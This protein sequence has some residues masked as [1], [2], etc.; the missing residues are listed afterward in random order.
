MGRER[1]CTLSVNVS[2]HQVD[3]VFCAALESIMDRT[4]FPAE[5]LELEITESAL[6][7]DPKLALE[8]LSRWKELG[9]RIALDDFGTGYCSLSYLSQLPVDRVKLDK[10]FTQTIV[11]DRRNAV[12]VRAVIDLCGEMG[13]SVLAEGVETELQLEMLKD[14]GCGHAQGYLMAS[15]APQ[16]IARAILGKRWGNRPTPTVPRFMSLEEARHAS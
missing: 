12:I 5:R 10:S 15:P 2:A 16:H 7:G 11:S 9:V 8:C 6:F 14:Y 1:L 3:S 13:I 4:G